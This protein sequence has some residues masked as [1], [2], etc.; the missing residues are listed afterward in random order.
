MSLSYLTHLRARVCMCLCVCVVCFCVY[1]CMCECVSVC[2]PVCV[3]VFLCVYMYVCVCVF[4]PVLFQFNFSR[5]YLDNQPKTTKST[6]TM[7]LRV[8]FCKK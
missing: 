7:T 2:I 8:V 4:K 5:I 1:T 6:L 3:S